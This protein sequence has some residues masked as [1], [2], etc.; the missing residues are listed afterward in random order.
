MGSN[1]NKALSHCKLCCHYKY[2]VSF[3]C[4]SCAG[5]PIRTCRTRRSTGRTMWTRCW[6]NCAETRMASLGLYALLLS[7]FILSCSPFATLIHFTYV[8]ILCPFVSFTLCLYILSLCSKKPSLSSI[9][10]VTKTDVLPGYLNG[11]T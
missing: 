1:E 2:I 5:D 3:A 9:D 10:I 6:T 8:V 4:C 11:L 7:L